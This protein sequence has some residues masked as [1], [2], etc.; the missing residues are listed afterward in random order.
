VAA[1]PSRQD[2]VCLGGIENSFKSTQ[3]PQNANNKSTDTAVQRA[4]IKCTLKM[5]ENTQNEGNASK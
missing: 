3:R 4:R 2:A 5:L 1:F